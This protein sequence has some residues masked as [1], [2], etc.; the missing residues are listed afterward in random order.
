MEFDEKGTK[1]GWSA[2]KPG[3]FAAV[4]LL[5]SAFPV[6][7]NNEAY[8]PAKAVWWWRGAD[9]SDPA[10]AARR[11]EFLALRGI[12]EIYFCCD[13]KKP[14]EVRSFVKKAGQKGMRVALLAGDVSWIYPGNRGFAETLRRFTEYQKSASPNERFYALHLDVE[15]HQDAKLS[16]ARKWQL[17]ADFVLR[18]AADVHAAGEKIEWDIPFWLDGIRV[19]FGHRAEVPLLEVVMGCSDAVALMS[20]RDT[21]AAILDISSTEIAMAKERMVRVILGAETGETGEGDFV[22]FFE[23]GPK[24]MGSELA[25]VMK[26]LV[27]SEIPAGCGVAVHHLGSWEKLVERAKVKRGGK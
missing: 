1:K 3:L 26:K 12:N 13:L 5:I 10:A 9:A 27:A 11:F 14:A 2:R 4:C 21:A 19:A 16:D 24:V 8:R 15:P 17:Y 18:A 20:Y 22:T 6:F 25:A 23:E 7:A